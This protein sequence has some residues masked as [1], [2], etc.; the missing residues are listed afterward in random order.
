MTREPHS[1]P[2]SSDIRDGTQ[3][4]PHAEL[5][6][7]K[8][9]PEDRLTLEA[10]YN[11]QEGSDR[12]RMPDEIWPDLDF[13]LTQ[14]RTQRDEWSSDQP[15]TQI[16]EAL[17][18]FDERLGLDVRDIEN[19]M[20]NNWLRPQF[21]PDRELW[22]KL[23]WG[24]EEARSRI[25]SYRSEIKG[26]RFRRTTKRRLHAE[27]TEVLQNILHRHGLSLVILGT[28]QK[29]DIRRKEFLGEFFRVVE[30]PIDD[31]LE[32]RLLDGI[33]KLIRQKQKKAQC[34]EV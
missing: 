16:D 31:V 21:E 33:A 13:L 28:K 3:P 12:S 5:A 24:I 10:A 32:R 8:F 7:F 18:K 34:D 27:T 26:K 11:V 20:F 14:H 23:R 2:S 30:D 15:K 29:L 17:S 9:N 25:R 1:G 19:L 6:P 22:A 4:F